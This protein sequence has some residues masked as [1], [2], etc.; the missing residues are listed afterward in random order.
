MDMDPS[1]R[2]DTGEGVPTVVQC[3][4]S[5]TATAW[6]AVEVQVQSLAQHSCGSDSVPGRG[7]STFCGCSHKKEKKKR[8]KFFFQILSL[9]GYYRILSRDPCALQ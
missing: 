5:L 9:I 1:F 8:K 6:I 3:V 2:N 4:K 7:T